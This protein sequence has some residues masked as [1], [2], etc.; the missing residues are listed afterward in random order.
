MH[1]RRPCVQLGCAGVCAAPAT[2]LNIEYEVAKE[3]QRDEFAHPGINFTVSQYVL[4]TQ[5]TSPG[6]RGLIP[7]LV[8]N[9][10][11]IHHW[12]TS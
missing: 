10:S 8:G 3:R 5:Q 6:Q 9:G 7:S 11:L 4:S 2:W 12:S 1:G